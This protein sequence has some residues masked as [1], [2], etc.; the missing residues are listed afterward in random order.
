M[1]ALSVLW[2]PLLSLTACLSEKPI[3]TDPE[4]VPSSTFQL[5]VEGIV[6]PSA[7]RSLSMEPGGRLVVDLL[8]PRLGVHRADSTSWSGQEAADLAFAALPEGEGYSIRCRYRD[9]LG[10]LT[11]ADSL[12]GLRLGRGEAARVAMLLHPLLGKIFLNAPALPASVDTLGIVWSREGAR[13]EAKVPRGPGGRT[14]LRL[15]SLPV[16]KSGMASVRA[17]TRSGDT[18]FHLDT[19]L[20]LSGDKDLPLALSMQNSRGDFAVAFGSIPGG[21]LD[22]TASFPGE[23]G[24]SASQTGRLLLSSFSDSGASDWIGIYNPGPSFSGWVRLGK[25][26]GDALLR[27]DLPAGQEAIATRAPCSALEDTTHVLHG[28]H[29]LLCAIEEAIVTHSASGGSFWKMRDS[30][31]EVLFDAVYVLDGRQGWPDLNSSDANT[32]R[33]KGSARDPFLNDVGRSW[34]VDS[35]IPE[36]VCQ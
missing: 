21:E 22:I 23:S 18:L 27:L 20:T 36:S 29:H 28:R 11:H 10:F 9:P 2:F 12:G 32:V 35:G 25:G 3:P 26:N 7:G 6:A 1:R 33:M 31:G 8:N 15:D 19:L 24:S 30:S 34:C 4:S 5:H 14:M 17:W 16:A 13:R